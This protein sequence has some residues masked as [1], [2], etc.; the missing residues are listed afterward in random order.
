MGSTSLN[1]ASQGHAL[2][3]GTMIKT[4][5][6]NTFQTSGELSQGLNYLLEGT[7]KK[8]VVLYNAMISEVY[9]ELL[10]KYREPPLKVFTQSYLDML[11]DEVEAKVDN[12]ENL[13]ASRKTDDK[14]GKV[15]MAIF[16]E[17]SGFGKFGKCFSCRK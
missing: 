9:Q 7:R 6:L 13:L 4:M 14:T 15:E 5:L 11:V 12:E 8:N 2:H 1:A 10:V 16:H 3:I 17:E